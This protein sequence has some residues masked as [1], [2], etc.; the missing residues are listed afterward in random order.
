MWWIIISILSAIILV[1]G[2][3][4]Y[5]LHR[6]LVVAETVTSSY[7]N[8]LDKVS[9]VLEF[10]SSARMLE[11]RSGTRKVFKNIKHKLK[12]NHIQIGRDRFFSI[13]RDKELLIKRRKKTKRTTYSNHGYAVAPNLLKGKEINKINQVFVADIT[14]IP[15][16]NSFAS[17]R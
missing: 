10:V 17:G 2:Y 16:G 6:K 4:I 9:K 11:P 8:Y 3:I 12:R 14:Y 13:L 7:F 5:N 1:C 15:I